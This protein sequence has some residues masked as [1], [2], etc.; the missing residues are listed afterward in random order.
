MSA[1]TDF[2]EKYTE[3]DRGKIAFAWNGK[4]SV[5][6]EDAN[7][8]FRWEVI[9]ACLRLP[10]QAPLLLLEHLFL[11]DSEWSRQA[12][13]SPRHFAG[14]G[15][16]LLMRGK[17]AALESF[18]HGFMAS[19]DTFG[20]CHEICLSSDVLARLIRHVRPMLEVDGERRKSLD[21]VIA[22]FSKLQ[23]R[24]AHEGWVEIGSVE[25]A[26]VV[27][28]RWYCKAWGEISSLWRGRAT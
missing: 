24:S 19:F 11:A 7:Q 1:V 2:I 3:A 10:E 18:M 4:H 15:G 14:L 9:Q 21:S 8:E 28:R 22:L 26:S 17:E 23:E 6:F 12:W 5:D 20:A 27:R 13:G 16:A 25:S